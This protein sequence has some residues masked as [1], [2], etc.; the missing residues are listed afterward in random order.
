MNHIP[1]DTPGIYLL[2]SAIQYVGY[3][4]RGGPWRDA[5]VRYG[6]DPRSDP[7]YRIYQTIFFKIVTDTEPL[8]KAPLGKPWHDLRSEY[9]RRAN[10]EG[11]DSNSHIFDG[12]SISLD[13]KLW[14]VC[15]IT[16]P[17]L[18]K[19][20]STETLRKECDIYQ[21]GW[22]CNGTWAKV[23]AIMRTKISA[24][25][26]GR[27]MEEID[28]RQTLKMPDDVVGKD[29][30]TAYAPDLRPRV[31]PGDDGEVEELVEGSGIPLKGK[32]WRRRKIKGII[33]RNKKGLMGPDIPR[34]GR[35]RSGIGLR[36]GFLKAGLNL[37]SVTSSTGNNSLDARD[38]TSFGPVLSQPSSTFESRSQITSERASDEPLTPES[39]MDE[40]EDDD[41]IF[42]EEDEDDDDEGEDEDDEGED[43]DED[44]GEEDS[45]DGE[46]EDEMEG[47]DE[48]EAE[49]EGDDE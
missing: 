2:K 29:R 31:Q 16:D 3:Q 10:P 43:G 30:I 49:D 35:M 45:E 24:I 11:L 27:E 23:R 44:D 1:R 9:T 26:I 12:T 17:L 34:I 48:D 33:K 14:Q 36:E 42:D 6:V 22:F 19:L 47:E 41:E 20:L 46:D 7:S 18:V 40:D 37:K 5:I 4:F 28:F 39:E 13:G 38:N 21:D 15:D 32:A 25:R 8:D